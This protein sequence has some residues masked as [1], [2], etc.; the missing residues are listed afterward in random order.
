MSI[1][2]ISEPLPGERVIGLAPEDAT[3]ASR[4]WLRRPN[5]F[6]SRT[7]TAPT[8]EGRQDWAAA[9]VALRGRAYTSGIV[10]GLEAALSGHAG[11]STSGLGPTRL[12]LMQGHALTTSGEDVRIAQA[13]EVLL[14]NLPVV[15]APSVFA[16]SSGEDSGDTTGGSATRSRIIGRR[17]GDMV[18]ARPD[19]LPRVGILL[20]QPVSADRIGE[21]DAQDPCALDGCGDDGIV[22]F[23]DWRIG[24]AARLLW[25]AWPEEWQTLPAVPTEAAEHWRNLI[26][27]QVFDG[28]R[29][30]AAD[31]QL[32]WEAY[33]VPIGLVACDDAWT[34][35][36]LDRASVVR[37]GGRARYARLTGR[38]ERLSAHWRWPALWQA[39]IEQ[40]AE[41]IAEAG[42]A[43]LDAARLGAQFSRLPPFGLLPTS[44]VDLEAL[45]SEFFPTGYQLDATPVPLEQLDAV[46]D[47]AA[48]L[49]PLEPG[50]GERVRILVP[51]PQ[52]VFDP[53]LLNDDVIDPRFA[54]TLNEF[55]LERARWL[56]ARQGLRQRASVTAR[57]ISGR[58]LKVPLISEDKQALETEA[59]APWG[60]PPAGGG[61]RSTLRNGLHQHFFLAASETMTVNAREQLFAWV[62]LDPDNPPRTLMLQ[63]H[64]G[65]WEHRAYWGDNRINWGADGT[66]SRF[67]VD[68]L[69]ALGR[70]VRLTVTAEQVGLSG[71]TPSGMAFTLY[72]G[73]AAYGMTGVQTPAGEQR[74]WFCSVL[75]EDAQQNGDERW[76]FLSHNDLWAPFESLQPVTPINAQGIDDAGGH[77]EPLGEGMHRHEFSG[78]TVTMTPQAGES[79]FV[80]VFIDPNQPPSQLMLQWRTGTSTEHRAYWGLSRISLGTEGTASRRR[81]DALPEPGRWERLEVPVDDVGLA[82]APVT[83]MAFILFDGSAAFGATGRLDDDGEEQVWFADALPRGATSPTRWRFLDARDLHAPTSAGRD[84]QVADL[85]RLYG[86]ST[87]SHLSQHERY[88]LFERGLDGFI[89]YLKERADRADDLVDYSFVKV[90]TDIYRVRQLVLG[91]TDATRL[92]ISPALAG[93]A[94]AETAVASSEQI[95]TFFKELQQEQPAAAASGAE[96]G[97]APAGGNIAMNLA[98]SGGASRNTVT[99][100][101]GGNDIVLP[102]KRGGRTIDSKGGAR[103]LVDSGAGKSDQQEKITFGKSG[104]D[105]RKE[106][107]ATQLEYATKVDRYTPKDITES[108]P[109]IG[110]AEVRTVSI[111]ER[112][113]AP[114]AAE[115]KDYATSS[116]YEAV[117]SL[118]QYADELTALDGGDV[119]GLFDGLQF[120]GLR[121]DPVLFYDAADEVDTDNRPLPDVDDPANQDTLN[122]L[123]RSLPFATL[124][125]ERWRLPLMLRSPL[126]SRIDES[127]QFSEGVDLSDNTVAL[128]RQL[129]GRIKRYRNAIAAAERLRDELSGDAAALEKR[130]QSIGGSLA[131]ARHDVSV[132]RALI[133]EEQARLD[134][135]NARRAEIRRKYVRFLAFQR[136]REAELIEEPAVRS[137]DPGLLEAPLPVCLAGRA[138]NAP[139]E[140]TRLLALLREAPASWFKRAPALIKQLD[141]TDLLVKTVQSAQLRAQLFDLKANAQP[142][143]T[144]A[145]LSG[146][147]AA[148]ASL[149]AKRSSN[150]HAYRSKAA[151]F[152]VLA[153]NALSWQGAKQQVE[154][155]VSLGDLI[156]GEHGKGR[157][158]QQAA[159]LFDEIAKVAA[160]MHAS[161]S[162]VDPVYRLAWVDQLSQFDATPRLRNL[163]G[164]PRWGELEYAERRELQGYA[165]WLFGQIETGNADAEELINDLIHLCLL[166]A[167]H[168]P[169]NRIISGNLPEPVTVRPG[170]LL[171]V[172]VVDVASMKIGM[173][174]LV[175]QADRV[176]A[177]ATV[178]DLSGS[179]ATTKVIYTESAEMTLAAN[180]RVQFVAQASPIAMT[181]ARIAG[182]TR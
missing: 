97:P 103:V 171:P 42:E 127:M 36:F 117:R 14:A 43:S 60:P 161:F 88:Q 57:A 65:D 87:L 109:L 37:L 45:R 177:R 5:L 175:Y 16:D 169:V 170:V 168:A 46:V 61:H 181:G 1:K 105:I 122:S 150:I 71:S 2:P 93:I 80:R 84:G 12:T 106:R 52:A 121:G 9:H 147:N 41:Q 55:L 32:P 104:T 99:A 78:A 49:A 182:V 143:P 44:A 119:P 76:Q 68:D 24:D 156:D 40:F 138:E 160:C 59:L 63:W 107:D 155:V 81:V 30:L 110:K 56:G 25:F 125:A 64:D 124:M 19:A 128:M 86:G 54:I 20:L 10:D 142:Q 4:W 66:V 102:Q 179:Q 116:R 151:Q 75:P 139:D 113:Q 79:L 53:H 31:Q 176:V 83:G 26:A 148:I 58:A 172:N 166:L 11:S 153:L 67:R 72:D 180:T 152:D 158:V 126:H 28:E 33:G 129:E 162:E 130:L 100:S 144:L 7:L 132:T 6:P 140:L 74:K 159:G 35:Q 174:A 131:E 94:Q 120:H 123:R 13:T 98:T 15:A 157:I 51:V 136:P 145:A 108:A 82:G 47:E 178:D 111:A 70:W 92:A 50:P 112:L 90:Q 135:I 8:L 133:A 29:R 34:P 173:Q 27:W 23:E 149:Q 146:T 73:Q 165:D 62:Y 118:M 48:S 96:R 95:S 69:P 114:K 21:F 115:A 38:P 137:L 163:A 17:L 18:A 141:R 91:T 85:G 77:V 167:S 154:E 101:R 22:A 89:A 3:D 39:Q 134:V 164:L